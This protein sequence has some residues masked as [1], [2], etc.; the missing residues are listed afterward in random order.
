[1]DKNAIEA[2]FAVFSTR[3]KTKRENV[4]N[5]KRGDNKPMSYTEDVQKALEGNDEAFKSLY[6]ST[7]KSKLYLAMKYMKNKEK[8]ED[9]LQEAYM[10]AFLKL[11]TL[12]D[13]ETFSSWL[14]TIVVNKAKNALEKNNPL[15]FS[16]ITDEDDDIEFQ[17][18][19]ENITFRP[20]MNFSRQE[21]QEIVHQL[22]DDLPDAQR[23]CVLMRYIE[24]YKVREIA[25]ILDCSE[26]TVQSRLKYGQQKMKTKAEE[27]QKKGYTLRSIAPVTL[28]FFL[29][30]DELDAMSQDPSFVESGNTVRSSVFEQIE[31]SQNIQPVSRPTI[32]ASQMADAS[33]IATGA[34]ASAPIIAGILSSSVGKIGVTVAVA[35]AAIGIGMGVTNSSNRNNRI[36]DDEIMVNDSSE[37]DANGDIQII[38]EKIE[39][40][41]DTMLSEALDAY[42]NILLDVPNQEN[43]SGFLMYR[44]YEYGLLFMEDTDV[45]PTLLLKDS[46]EPGTTFVKLFWYQEDTKEV[47]VPIDQYN[48][49]VN[50]LFGIRGGIGLHGDK[51][52][53]CVSEYWPGSDWYERNRYTMINNGTS[54][55]RENEFSG[56]NFDNRVM[57]FPKNYEIDWRSISDLTLFD[58]IANG[59][60]RG[61]FEHDEEPEI[62]SQEVQI[63]DVALTDGDRIVLSGIVVHYTYD[64]LL[65]L[66]P[67][68]DVNGGVERER[69]YW[70]IILDDKQLLSVSSSISIPGGSNVYNVDTTC[71]DVQSWIDVE[72]YENQHITFSIDSNTCYGP[73][74]TR[75]PLG[76]P[77]TSDIHVL[78]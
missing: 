46:N 14:G 25:E 73:S 33:K 1:M 17:I 37:S 55:N 26:Q 48:Q 39:I 11:D 74:D 3:G 2:R 57:G 56:E 77:I 13:P 38:E 62:I 64:Q 68:S 44:D 52:G 65:E 24:G 69:T 36:I 32:H 40:E 21:T 10:K 59:E 51:R 71:I 4:S 66:M 47:V 54:I 41:E 72:T 28:L 63:E 60:T 5:N 45:I 42:K 76:Q 7:Y 12:E 29:F 15:S 34:T 9:V 31:I 50:L 19:D 22:I 27:L 49:E 70:L 61:Y 53:L 16:D 35:V 18:E 75:L 67:G 8:A 43:F 78:Q 30:R 23:L 58:Q 20:E 6:E